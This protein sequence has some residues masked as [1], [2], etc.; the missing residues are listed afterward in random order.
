MFAVIPRKACFLHNA[1][2]ASLHASSMHFSFAKYLLRHALSLYPQVLV[3]SI[4]LISCF[5]KK[6]HLAATRH[7]QLLQL[8][9]AKMTE[10]S[11]LREQIFS[12][13]RTYVRSRKRHLLTRT[14][15]N[16]S[17][18]YTIATASMEIIV[19]RHEDNHIGQNS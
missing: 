1:S 11:G 6:C 4:S 17:V 13:K 10:I 18:Q 14:T 16:A 8:P 7:K 15:A 5:F 2:P 9:P 12:E 3:S 19:L